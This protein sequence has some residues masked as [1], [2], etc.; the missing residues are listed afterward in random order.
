MKIRNCLI[1]FLS[2]ILL[3]AL[4]LSLGI[5]GYNTFISSESAPV[6]KGDSLYNEIEFILKADP[7]RDYILVAMIG[8]DMEILMHVDPIQD[9]AIGYEFLVKTAINGALLRGGHSFQLI[10]MEKEVPGVA[11]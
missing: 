4:G 6:N 3:G 10:M 2:M 7:S 5:Y 1:A 9:W 11:I 8:S